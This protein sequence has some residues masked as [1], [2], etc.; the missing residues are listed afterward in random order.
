MYSS[1]QACAL[2]DCR[3]LINELTGRPIRKHC[4]SAPREFART[5]PSD[6]MARELGRE[7]TKPAKLATAPPA[8][9]PPMSAHSH[10]QIGQAAAKFK[11]TS[12]SELPSFTPRD[13]PSASRRLVPD[14]RTRHPHRPRL[15]GRRHSK[16][17]VFEHLTADLAAPPVRAG[18]A[19]PYRRRWQTFTKSAPTTTASAKTQP[20]AARRNRR[21]AT[22]LTHSRALSRLRTYDILTKKV[23]NQ[24]ARLTNPI[25]LRVALTHRTR[26]FHPHQ[27][28]AQPTPKRGS[29][30]L[31]SRTRGREG[32]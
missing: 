26:R 9:G 28:R 25:L 19:D 31:V 17:Y 1:E 20:N 7:D 29:H 18:S 13:T 30:R 15:L 24:F 3:I 23:I 10:P 32:R 5:R 12:A 22:A 16:S 14:S 11:P 6:D 21:A 27:A 4:C 2:P 8:S